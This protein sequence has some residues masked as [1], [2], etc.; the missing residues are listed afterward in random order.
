MKPTPPNPSSSS[1]YDAAGN[2]HMAVQPQRPDLGT[3]ENFAALARFFSTLR[4]RLNSGM[5]AQA[6][7]QYVPQAPLP[8]MAARRAAMAPEAPAERQA[9][10]GTITGYPYALGTSVNAWQPGMSFSA[11]NAPVAIRSGRS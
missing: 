2:E 7:Q 6:L 4:P 1:T 11:E 8:D 3:Q 10:F 5:Q 9:Q